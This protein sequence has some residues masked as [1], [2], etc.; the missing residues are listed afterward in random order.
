MS[1]DSSPAW[2]TA[3]RRVPATLNA[4]T[5]PEEKYFSVVVRREALEGYI[6]SSCALREIPIYRRAFS[7]VLY[8]EGRGVVPCVRL[9]SLPRAFGAA[10]IFDNLTNLVPGA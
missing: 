2:K 9:A 3:Q 8:S 10:T 6:V 7:F 4:Q 5:S 1:Y